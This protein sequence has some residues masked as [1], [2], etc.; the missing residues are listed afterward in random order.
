MPHP[1]IECLISEALFGPEPRA[2]ALE[3]VEKFLGLQSI[4]IGK[5][6]IIPQNSP[7][8]RPEILHNLFRMYATHD[9]EFIPQLA[10]AAQR[11]G[12]L[13][14]FELAAVS[15]GDSGDSSL[16]ED[17]RAVSRRATI[18]QKANKTKFA[19]KVLAQN[20]SP[21]DTLAIIDTAFPDRSS[22]QYAIA[23]REAVLNLLKF[24]QDKTELDVLLDRCD[25][26]ALWSLC[27]ELQ[28]NL[29]LAKPLLKKL[30]ERKSG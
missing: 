29:S 12:F 20:G 22:V 8:L 1:N 13:Q 24:P 5:S 25:E 15:I 14:A 9:P 2:N 23:L 26:K 28:G 3:N 4:R 7:A 6:Q 10:S 17:S 16:G 11:A 27:S 18:Y 30:Q 21:R 19:V